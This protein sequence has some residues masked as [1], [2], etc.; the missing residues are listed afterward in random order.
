[1]KSET[2]S[3]TPANN[4]SVCTGAQGARQN[5]EVLASEGRHDPPPGSLSQ[6]MPI[7]GARSSGKASS[8][9]TLP[10]TG[11]P[12][13]EVPTSLASSILIGVLEECVPK[14]LALREFMSSVDDVDGRLLW[15]V[16]LRRL[17]E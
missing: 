9:A 13:L 12:R 14:F 15:T 2:R 1:M 3:S 11:L 6:K 4:Q 7:R 10:C 5:T 16:S 17:L 8:F